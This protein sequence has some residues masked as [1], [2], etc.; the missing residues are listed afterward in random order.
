MRRFIGSG[1]WMSEDLSALVRLGRPEN[2]VSIR[3][4]LRPVTAV[5]RGLGCSVERVAWL[6]G[7]SGFVGRWRSILLLGAFLAQRAGGVRV[8]LESHERVIALW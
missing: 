7:S 4:D 3:G 1:D 8:F 2:A 5:R 6:N